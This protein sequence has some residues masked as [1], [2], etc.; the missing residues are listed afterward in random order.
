MNKTVQDAL[1]SPRQ[2]IRYEHLRETDSFYTVDEGSLASL[3][4][5]VRPY[6][7]SAGRMRK[8]RIRVTRDTNTK[9]VKAQII[10]QRIADL[11][12]INPGEAFDCRISVNIEVHFNED[13]S[14]FEAAD[15]SPRMKDR[16]SYQH[17]HTSIDLTQ[18]RSSTSAKIHELEVEL[19]AERIIEQGM[20][21]KQGR[22]DAC[23]E[24]MVKTFV[25]NIRIL[26]R[27]ATNM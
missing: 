7:F 17:L 8:P 2:N 24:E 4:P 25:N 26:S 6:I 1:R 3:P 19:S 27:Q 12:I 10:K 11:D 9:E 5:S 18:V 22:P 14:L 15:E 20:W 16:M 13:I 23:Y 21:T